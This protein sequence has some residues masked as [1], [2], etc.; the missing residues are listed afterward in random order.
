MERE[1]IN[2]KKALRGFSLAVV[3]SSNPNVPYQ[4]QEML[5]DLRDNSPNIP[6]KEMPKKE[7]VL[8]SANTETA[9]PSLSLTPNLSLS[10]SRQLLL[11]TPASAPESLPALSPEQNRE[12]KIKLELSEINKILDEHPNV[13][14]KKY[15]TDINLYYPIYKLI[16]DKFN[17]DWYL[18]FIVHENETGASAGW[19]GFTSESYYKGA[20]QRDPNIW[21]EDFVDKAAEGL[22]DLA[23]FP[24]RHKDDW[25]EIAAGAAILERNIVQYKSEGNDTAVRKALL[26]YSANG[27]AEKRFALY[28]RYKPMFGN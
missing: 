3:I 20:M 9:P 12:Q 25:R 19:R 2:F 27:P 24:Q 7:D 10:S 6:G 11:K 5:F 4:N 23:G 21:T 22:E 15:K 28:E 18:I 8:F 14:S 13:F 17:I 16:A 1:K 26:L